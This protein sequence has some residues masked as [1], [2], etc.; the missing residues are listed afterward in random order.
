M[1]FRHHGELSR[2]LEKME[3]YFLYHPN[4]IPEQQTYAYFN[5]AYVCLNPL[6]LILFIPRIT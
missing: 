1:R 6:I 4:A 5:F 2:R 3:G